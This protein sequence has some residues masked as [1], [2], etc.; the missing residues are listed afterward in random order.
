MKAKNSFQIAS[1]VRL[2]SFKFFFSIEFVVFEWIIYITFP[3][4]FLKDNLQIIPEP[5]FR[6]EPTFL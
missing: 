5:F 6:A 2:P 3:I 4:S 1:F